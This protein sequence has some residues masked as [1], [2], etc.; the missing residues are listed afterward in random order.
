MVW[1][2]ARDL[3]DAGARDRTRARNHN[4]LRGARA[5]RPF[6]PM[7][8]WVRP[9]CAPPDLRARRRRHKS[10]DFSGPALRAAKGRAPSPPGASQR[11]SGTHCYLG[12]WASV[13]DPLTIVPA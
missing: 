13:G 12:T 11:R 10:R 1:P 7:Y 3:R 5:L 4:V 2:G 9:A 6:N 8:G